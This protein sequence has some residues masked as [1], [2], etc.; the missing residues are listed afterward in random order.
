MDIFT[1]IATIIIIWCFVNIGIYIVKLGDKLDFQN[2]I[3]T[4]INEQIERIL[5]G[6][7]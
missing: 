3:L 6:K 2:R 1:I 5:R 4:E 7:L